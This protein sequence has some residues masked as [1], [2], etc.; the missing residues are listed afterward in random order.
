MSTLKRLFMHEMD[1]LFGLCSTDP[2][3]LG[4]FGSVFNACSFTKVMFYSAAVPPADDN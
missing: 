4:L 2:V 3:A 1:C